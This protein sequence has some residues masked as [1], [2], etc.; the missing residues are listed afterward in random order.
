MP[1]QITSC[2]CN[3]NCLDSLLTEQHVDNNNYRKKGMRVLIRLMTLALV[4]SSLHISSLIADT[5]T[6]RKDAPSEYVVKKGDT[7]WDISS[8]FLNDPWLWPKL[9]K[10][11]PQIKNPHLIYPGDQLKLVYEADGSPKLVMAKRSFSLS[12]QKRIAYKKDEPIPMVPLNAIESFLS[13]E[14]ALDEDTLESLPYVLGTD[15][16]VKR[17]LPGDLLYIKGDLKSESK[18]AI[19]RKGKA[20]VDPDSEDILG[21]EAV[22]VAVAD[23]INSGDPSEGVPGKI[24]I[25]TAKQEVRASD[26]VMPIRQGQ[27]LPA[28][29]KMAKIDTELDGT[30]VA[31]PSDLAGVSKYDVVIINKGQDSQVLAGNILTISRK[32]PTVVDQGLG[33]KYQ[34]DATRYEKFVGVVKNLF[35]GDEHK[36]IYDMPYEEVGQ[37]MIFKVYEKVSY[38]II[39]KNSSPI[40]V[41]DKINTPNL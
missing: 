24:R 12:P 20:Y 10:F 8:L 6:I 30:I 21:Y 35:R 40:Y 13:Y 19:Y 1:R 18:F 33:P 7:L 41:G 32:S 5:L 11:N 38:G 31:T 17:A 16:T 29:F 4:I 37:V 9:W 26:V 28:F 27:D 3:F 25:T 36:G 23:L 14:L 34:E 22:L 2:T 15:R 39:T